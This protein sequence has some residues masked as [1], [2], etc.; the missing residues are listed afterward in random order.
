LE[1]RASVVLEFKS[2]DGQDTY[3]LAKSETKEL[4]SFFKNK[5]IEYLQK[6]IAVRMLQKAMQDIT[7]P[8]YKDGSFE[9]NEEKIKREITSI[10]EIAR[11]VTIKLFPGKIA[12]PDSAN[13]SIVTFPWNNKFNVRH[14]KT[15]SNEKKESF[16]DCIHSWLDSCISLGYF[17]K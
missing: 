17:N 16:Q 5:K 12:V 3:D 1:K 6:D 7:L 9:K 13:F 14:F 15:F 4:L 2:P 11:W 10:P 8:Y